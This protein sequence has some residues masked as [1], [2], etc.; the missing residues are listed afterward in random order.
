ME[1]PMS[2]QFGSESPGTRERA[3]SDLGRDIG[4]AASE[5]VS[6]LSDAAN[7]ATE[8]AKQSAS[9]AA[10]S[11]T[12]QVKDVLDRQVGSGADIVGH[13]ANSAKRA[14][15]DLERNA[16]QLAG[17]VRGVAGRIDGFADSMRDQSV[18]ELLRTASDFTRRKPA[19][20]FGLAALAGFFVFRTLKASPSGASTSSNHSAAGRH[21]GA[22]QFNGL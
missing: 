13:V 4:K 21:D 1:V 5:A 17:L 20:V 11:V 9:D 14:A 2:N 22:R 3:S 8:K 6:F 15:D 10:S 16:P 18:D 19:L 12:H 7:Q